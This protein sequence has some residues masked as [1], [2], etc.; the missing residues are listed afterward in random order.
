MATV[1]IGRHHVNDSGSRSLQENGA[2]HS[3]GDGCCSGVLGFASV[4]ER[5]GQCLERNTQHNA[6][7]KRKMF[8][9]KFGRKRDNREICLTT[10]AV[11]CH[12]GAITD[13]DN[14]SANSRYIVIV[15]SLLPICITRT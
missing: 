13:S 4:A 5:D 8:Y 3:P 12:Y 14:L 10:E 15:M 9:L 11:S 2:P 7:G 1:H 6:C